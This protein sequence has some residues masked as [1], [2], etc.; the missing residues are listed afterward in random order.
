M[1]G[2]VPGQWGSLVVASLRKAAAR[3]LT[4]NHLLTHG[5]HGLSAAVRRTPPG[6]D[7]IPGRGQAGR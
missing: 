6:G 5:N 3:R 2:A 7:A 4:G 1:N